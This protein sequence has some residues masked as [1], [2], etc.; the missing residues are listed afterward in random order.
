[1]TKEGVM[2]DGQQG[3]KYN[4]DIVLCIDATG[5]MSSIIDRVK[6]NAIRFYDDLSSKLTSKSK[7]VAGLRI[8]VIAFRD[9]YDDPSDAMNISK[10]F[11]L[12]DELPGFTSFVNAIT[13]DK[14]GDAPENSLEALALAIKS[15]WMTSGHR[16]RQIIVMWTD[17]NAH[18]LDQTTFPRPSNYPGDMPNDFN[19]MSDWWEQGYVDLQAK[20]LIIYAP[21][22]YPWTDIA[23]NWSMVIHHTSKAGSGLSDIDYQ[24]ILDT[25]VASV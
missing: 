8:K 16:R 23:T 6:T 12:P 18:P 4:V 1:L 15:D 22:T 17:T 20:R 5:S 21:D 13:A 24:T 11:N 14:G 25:I 19:K 9:Y 7:N 2:V 3:V 10:F